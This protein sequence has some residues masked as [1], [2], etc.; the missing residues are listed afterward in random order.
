[1]GTLT[2]F[3][4]GNMK[5]EP[6]KTGIVLVNVYF[7]SF[8]IYTYYIYIYIIN[9][10]SLPLLGGSN[11]DHEFLTKVP[12]KRNTHFLQPELAMADLLL[13][14]SVTGGSLLH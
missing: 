14:C 2:L 8:A 9:F 3:V 4:A 12:F 10:S 7:G 1:M 13:T 5:V 11:T 6:P